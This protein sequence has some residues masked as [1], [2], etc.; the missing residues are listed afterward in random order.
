VADV[1]NHAEYEDRATALNIASAFGTNAAPL[2]PLSE[3]VTRGQD[4]RIMLAAERLKWSVTGNA[5]S[6]VPVLSGALRSSDRPRQL[7]AIQMIGTMGSAA[8]PLVPAL[9][10]VLSTP[11]DWL[12]QQFTIEALQEMGANAKAALPALT[13]QLAH[14]VVKVREAAAHAIE[15]ISAAEDGDQP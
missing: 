13:N 2:L 1:L 7:Q 8:E 14:A 3:H 10:E 9:I 12:V 11:Q 6:L 15:S 5:D 4:F